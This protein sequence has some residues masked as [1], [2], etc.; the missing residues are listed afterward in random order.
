MECDA[1]TL[2]ERTHATLLRQ[3]SEVAGHYIAS[4]C[5]Q[6]VAGSHQQ[7]QKATVSDIAFDWSRHVTSVKCATL[8]IE[9]M[10]CASLDLTE[11]VKPVPLAEYT[12]PAPDVLAAPAPVF[13]YVA[14]TPGDKYI[15]RAPAAVPAVMQ[16]V[17]QEPVLH[18][19]AE[20]TV[21]VPVPKI[22]RG[23]RGS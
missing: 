18:D 6:K 9:I 2:L 5:P 12:V 4:G 16:S 15:V 21:D 22:L 23:T 19:A 3:L 17:P 14:P 13:G 8:I 20:Q 7:A 10:K 11:C 1:A